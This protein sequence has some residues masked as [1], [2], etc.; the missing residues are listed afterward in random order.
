M[1]LSIAG[2]LFLDFICKINA[3]LKNAISWDA[4]PCGSC[5]NRRFRGTQHLHHQGD[6][7][8]WARNVSSFFLRSVCQL[9]LTANVP[10]SPALV[11]LMMEALC[12]SN[13]SV[14]TRA[15]RHSIPEDGILHSH[16]HENIKSYI[17][18]NWLHLKD[19]WIIIWNINWY[20][21]IHTF[22]S[23]NS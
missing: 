11:T 22:P 17:M 20:F 10:T 2:N 6:K 21:F 15:T 18:V 23:S 8:R 12:S 13:M 16:L 1:L 14:L 7:N 19:I 4:M 3:E 5:K 9:L